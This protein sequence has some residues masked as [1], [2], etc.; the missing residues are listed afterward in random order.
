[1]SLALVESRF[2]EVELHGALPKVL[3]FVHLM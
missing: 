2:Q 1:M 3:V